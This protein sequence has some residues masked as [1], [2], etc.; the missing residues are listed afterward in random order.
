MVE[1][2]AVIVKLD[3]LAYS[4]AEA[5][6]LMGNVSKQ[7]IYRRIEDGSLRAFKW[8]GRTLIRVEDMQAALDAASGRT[9][10]EG[11]DDR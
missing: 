8:N 9:P 3:K 5:A 11:D 4:V 10:D 2:A 7:T 1:H 6:R